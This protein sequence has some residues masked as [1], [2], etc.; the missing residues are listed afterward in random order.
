MK[1]LLTLLLL[2]PAIS[3]GYG[4]SVVLNSDNTVR[5][6]DYYMQE[7]V[8]KAMKDLKKL[9]SPSKIDPIFL[10][11]NSGGGSIHWGNELIRFADNLNRPVHTITLFAASMGFQTVQ[12]LG[13]RFILPN[14]E[15]MS[16]KARG[17]VFGEFPGQLDVRLAHYKRSIEMGDL[18]TVKRTNGK[19]TLKSYTDLIENE[20]WCTS[21]DC[22]K[23]GF[24]DRVVNASCDAT[25][26]GNIEDSWKFMYM[27]VVIELKFVFDKCPLQSAML[28]LN[29]FVNG[30][31]IYEVENEVEEE[32]EFSY[33]SEPKK[34]A[35]TYDKEKILLEVNRRV[36]QRLNLKRNVKSEL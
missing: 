8:A 24:A 28:E 34:K 17:G 23:A 35:I 22:V 33:F 14:G 6:A 3:F 1:L 32:T 12:G 30:K 19:H 13:K 36:E 27:G 11:I 29:I 18:H 7:S 20:Y 16:H 25:M 26:V 5:F 31:D 2:L 10:V 4:E 15:L 21:S 9:D